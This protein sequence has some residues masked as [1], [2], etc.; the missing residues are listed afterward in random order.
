VPGA[1][2]LERIRATVVSSATTVTLAGNGRLTPASV[3]ESE[4]QPRR[5]VLDFPNV[6]SRAPVQT[7][8]DGSLVH[9][10]RQGLISPRLAEERAGNPQELRRLLGNVK[11]V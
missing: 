4:D 7:P 5:L 10:V 8:V 6:T 1:T 2:V 11:A 3:S 9:L